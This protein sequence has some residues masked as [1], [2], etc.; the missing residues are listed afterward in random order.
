MQPKACWSSMFNVIQTQRASQSMLRK[1]LFGLVIVEYI[2]AAYLWLSS[3][4]RSTSHSLFPSLRLLFKL[5]FFKMHDKLCPAWHWKLSLM[6]F[7]FRCRCLCK[8]DDIYISIYSSLFVIR[9]QSFLSKDLWEKNILRTSGP[10]ILQLSVMPSE[11]HHGSLFYI[12]CLKQGMLIES[13]WNWPVT[14]GGADIKLGRT[15][16]NPVCVSLF[17]SLV[18]V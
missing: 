1:G 14:D 10:G 8:P 5:H 18:R 13:I 12:K 15:S 16:P 11:V 7:K 6:N 2:F 3:C 17:F 4:L 9:L